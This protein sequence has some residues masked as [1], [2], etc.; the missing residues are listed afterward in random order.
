M[1]GPSDPHG[2]TSAPHEPAVFPRL[3]RTRSP[4]LSYR[5]CANVAQWLS[6]AAEIDRYH[7][8]APLPR[9]FDQDHT[10]TGSR[11]SVAPLG[12]KRRDLTACAHHPLD[13][14]EYPSLTSA[15]LGEE[16][17]ELSGALELVAIQ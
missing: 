6:F 7:C 14:L 10:V 12:V 17:S 11:E 3:Q 16:G 1:A 8:L 9:T 15:A 13:R 2:A 5:A 4:R